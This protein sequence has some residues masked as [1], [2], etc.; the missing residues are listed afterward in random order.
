M[1]TTSFVLG[2]D[3]GQARDHTALV[4]VERRTGPDPARPGQRAQLFDVRHVQR[5]QL[6]T[7]YVAPAGMPSVAGNVKALLALPPLAGSSPLLAVDQTGVG[8]GVVDLLRA[9]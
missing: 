5:L 1:A 7:P 9:A 2:L 3:L 6:G 8:R 4:V